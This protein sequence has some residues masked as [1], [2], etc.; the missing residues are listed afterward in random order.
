MF[1]NHL[2]KTYFENLAGKDNAFL[3]DLYSL[4]IVELERTNSFFRAVETTTEKEKIHFELHRLKGTLSA[5]GAKEAVEFVKQ[6]KAALGTNAD[7]WQKAKG[8]LIAM[9]S[10]IVQELRQLLAGI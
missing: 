4:S 6:E 7:N 1:N 3:S 8:N 9:I 5:I 2:S 10:Q